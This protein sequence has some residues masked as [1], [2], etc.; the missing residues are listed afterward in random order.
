MASQPGVSPPQ[1]SAK[2]SEKPRLR[3]IPSAEDLETDGGG[4][5]QVVDDGLEH[6]ELSHGQP[7]ARGPAPLQQHPQVWQ[8]PPAP[9]K[10]SSEDSGAWH[11]MGKGE[12][13]DISARGSSRTHGCP[14]RSWVLDPHQGVGAHTHTHMHTHTPIYT[15][16]H[17]SLPVSGEAGPFSSRESGLSWSHTHSC[18]GVSPSFQ[19]G[20]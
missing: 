7:E 4:P 8:S 3:Q 17:N 18:P 6:R 19:K 14:I 20:G 2:P 13:Y 1:R 12:R 15:H 16:T 11:K 10:V 9:Q 5:G